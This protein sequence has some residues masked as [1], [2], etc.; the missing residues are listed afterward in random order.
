M[1]CIIL[2]FVKLLPGQKLVLK[3]T[4]DVSPLWVCP[5]ELFDLIGLSIPKYN[6]ADILNANYFYLSY[7]AL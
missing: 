2:L 4:T 3:P 6:D 7:T 1:F 5:G